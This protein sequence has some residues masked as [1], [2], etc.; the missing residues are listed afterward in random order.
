[1]N[2]KE[3]K[4]LEEVWEW[5]EKAYK[6]IENLDLRIALKERIRKSIYTSNNLCFKTVSLVGK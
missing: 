2:Y 3:S 6:E 4:S 5:K 1:M